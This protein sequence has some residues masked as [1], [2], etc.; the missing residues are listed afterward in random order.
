MEN[1]KQSKVILV[2]GVSSGF[3]KET[4]RLLALK[5]HIVYGTIRK[6]NADAESVNYIIMDLTDPSSME[7][8]VEEVIRKEGRIDVLVNNGGMHTGGPAE[9]IPLEYARLQ[10]DTSFM[11]MVQMTRLVLPVMRRQS[12]GMIINISSL[13]GLM[14]LPFQSFYSASKFAMEGFSEALRMEVRKFNIKVVVINPGDFHTSNTVNRRGY[15]APVGVDDPYREQYKNALSVIENDETNG[16]NPVRLAEKISMIVD[17]RNPLQR[18]VV[19]SFDQK[20]ALFLKRILP[21]SLFMS[22]LCSHYRILSRVM[23]DSR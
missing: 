8:A 3:G 17:S 23:R 13:G 5:R 4:V 18:Y 2:T 21:E 9:T 10:M 12:S 15:L 7:R 11:G 6:G 16:G 22:L 20:L 1:P 19:A 14:G